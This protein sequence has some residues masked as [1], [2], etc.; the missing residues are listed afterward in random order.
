MRANVKAVTILV[1]VAALAPLCA[2]DTIYVDG[3]NGNDL[4]DG[5]CEVWDGGTCGPKATIQ[6][7]ILAASEADTVL[8]ADGTYTGPGNR[9]IDFGGLGIAVRSA[10][11]PQECVIDCENSGR[12]FTFRLGEGPA[13]SVLEGFTITH[14]NG[15]DP[16]DP[17][18]PNY[19]FV[20]GGA[21]RCY[22]GSSP[23][24]RN[25][26]I[27]ANNA[28]GGILCSPN[29][30]PRI[31]DSSFLNNVGT[32]IGCS[33]NSTMI[34]NCLIKEN[35]GGGIYCVGGSPSI[36]NCL[37][38]GN[39]TS[40]SGGG[41]ECTSGST[42][43][44]NNCTI[45]GN[46]AYAGGGFAAEFTDYPLMVRNCIIWGNV[47]TYGQQ[48]C[49]SW[50]AMTVAYSDI[51]AYSYGGGI[52]LG[53]A[54]VDW[55][56]DIDADPNFLDYYNGYY[57]LGR[58]SPCIDAGDNTAIPADAPDLDG[59]GDVTEPL[60]LDLAKMAR[61]IDIAAVPDTGVGTPPIVDMGCY[62]A[63]PVGDVNCDGVGDFG[64]INPF[65][66]LL[67]DQAAWQAM[68]PEC[69][70]LNGDINADGSVNFGDINPF[71]ALL[72]GR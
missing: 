45:V 38:A 62:E 56:H 2:A 54:T 71:V 53:N 7:G 61:F 36:N 39:W 29:S 14:G 21:I 46:H 17:Q 28:G 50:G 6:A 57:R 13:A 59:D 34:S 65:V 33:H 16:N 15:Q 32:A 26:W 63:S 18:D 10:N 47:A 23:T 52:F 22:N 42:A 43:T 24:I 12:G 44:V 58:N 3:T 72:A 25:C 19:P 60:P 70:F 8:V 67:T 51:M 9:I 27:V 41:I 49:V 20:G 40:W 11:G 5:L 64:D 4:W 30:S 48:M 35:S 66:L 1:V 55:Q 69:P 37:I 68:Y 31:V